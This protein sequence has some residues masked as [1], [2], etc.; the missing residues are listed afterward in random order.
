M[1]IIVVPERTGR[2]PL[3]AETEARRCR[4]GGR[5]TEIEVPPE[6][7]SMSYG[8]G[9]MGYYRLMDILHCCDIRRFEIEIKNLFNVLQMMKLN[10]IASSDCSQISVRALIRTKN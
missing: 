9:E 1:S 2:P 6:P 8:R 3:E 10:Q 4:V 7:I 5:E